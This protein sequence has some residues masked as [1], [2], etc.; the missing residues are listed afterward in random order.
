M[1]DISREMA[2]RVIRVLLE[3]GL[4]ARRGQGRATYYELL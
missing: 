3:Q 2:N 1:F 4:I